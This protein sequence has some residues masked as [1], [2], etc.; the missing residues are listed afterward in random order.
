MKGMRRRPAA[1]IIARRLSG[2]LSGA[3]W[4]GIPGSQRRGLAH[5]SISPRL[6]FTSF[7]RVMS[8]SVK[9]PAF[10]WGKSPW[11]RAFD[12][13]QCKYSTVLV[14]PR[15]RER[16][17]IRRER[18]LGLVAQAEERLGAAELSRK[19]ELRLDLRWRHRPFARVARRA[20]E[21]AVVA[22]VSAQVGEREKDLRRV[23]HH[24]SEDRVA[25][26]ARRGANR[27][28]EIAAGETAVGDRERLFVRE[29]RG[30]G[31][32]RASTHRG[33]QPIDETEV[34]SIS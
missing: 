8:A 3:R 17:A 34:G 23:R 30:Q 7:R 6:T 15:R 13:A 33:A 20:T 16:A 12:P 25:H 26:R 1:S 24:P 29:R 18:L 5:S 22:V 10:V 2:R 31:H 4:C 19:S 28:A 11:A 14:W 27:G 32:A 21:G 9:S